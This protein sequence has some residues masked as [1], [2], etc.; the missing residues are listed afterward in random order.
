MDLTRELMS[1]HGRR[2]ADEIADFVGSNP[3]HFNELIEVYLA[4]PYR[5]TQRAA[6]PVALCVQK[7]PD[8]V[9]PHLGKL[10]KFLRQPGIHNAVKR[11]TMRLLQHVAVPARYHGDVTS[12]CFHY[13]QDRKEQV[14]I[15]AFA[16]TV[17]Y[18]II[19]NEPDLCKELKIILEDELPYASA[20]FVSRAGKI[21]KA[22]DKASPR[23]Q[24]PPS[25]T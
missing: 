16:M 5:I 8:L 10:L 18:G 7:H 1:G 4:G 6:W 9:R 3:A 19:R 15:R 14:A 12:I 21:L 23:V 2:Q 20:A 24:F 25:G 11:N 17:V 22:I 13:L